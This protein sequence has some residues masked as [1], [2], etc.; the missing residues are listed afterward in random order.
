MEK[1]RSRWK[2]W[3]IDELIGQGAFGKVYKISKEDFGHVYGAALKI[4]EIPQNMSEVEYVRNEGMD[5]ESINSYFYGIAEDVVKEFELMSKLKGNTNIVSYED[6]MIEAKD[7]GYG[8]EISIRMEL[9][10]PLEKYIRKRMFS[11]K[12]VILLGIDI[13]ITF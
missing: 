5:E 7:N 12:D 6:H 8:W 13:C 9:L 11:V 3:K 1:D 2:E 4:I 10:T